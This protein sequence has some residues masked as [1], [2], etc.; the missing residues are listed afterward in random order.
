MLYDNCKS[1]YDDDE[2]EIDED[3]TLNL[4]IQSTEKW[5]SKCNKNCDT[6]FASIKLDGCVKGNM[7]CL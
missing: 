7:N 3:H 5:F 1:L 6:I 2:N 4:C